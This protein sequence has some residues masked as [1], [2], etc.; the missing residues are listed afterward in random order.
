MEYRR[1]TAAGEFLHDREI[2]RVA[3]GETGGSR[4]DVMTP[5]READGRVV[6]IDRG[7]IPV[8][9]Q[10]PAKRAAGQPAGLVRVTGILRL[11]PQE[12]PSVFLPE[13]KPER[14]L[15][16][17]LDL[18]AMAAAAKVAEVAPFYIVADATP[19]PGGWPKGREV[20]EP[21]PNNHLQYAITWFALAIAALVVYLLSQRSGTGEQS[22]S[23]KPRGGQ[24]EG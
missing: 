2:L 8:D 16:F 19:N 13:N 18:P 7:L 11:P 17:W 12:K 4:Y 23:D 21:L 1:V 14:N 10:D 5:L 20:A 3:A 22:R 24:G 9:L 15:W 6:F